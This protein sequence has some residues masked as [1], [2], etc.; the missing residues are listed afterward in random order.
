MNKLTLEMVGWAQDAQA[1]HDAPTS[2]NLAAAML[3]T[4]LGASA[5]AGSNNW[6]GTKTRDPT[7]EHTLRSEGGVWFTVAQGVY[8]FR[9]IPDSFMHYAW[10]E[11]QTDAGKVFLA[12]LREDADVETLTRSLSQSRALL[13][14]QHAGRLFRFNDLSKPPVL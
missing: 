13:A 12:S 10:R 14:F 3:A 9:T 6:H 8:M 1:G 5:P 2:L 11:T 7:N 4:E